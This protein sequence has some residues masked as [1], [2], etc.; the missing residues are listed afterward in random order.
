MPVS[1]IIMDLVQEYQPGKAIPQI[2]LKMKWRGEGAA[3]ERDISIRLS[4]VSSPNS[5]T[6]TCSPRENV[7]GIITSKCVCLASCAEWDVTEW[8]V[9]EWDVTEWDV[10]EWDVQSGM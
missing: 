4:G 3:V 1:Q 8:D 10:T 2:L 6:L 7:A 9:T 5:F